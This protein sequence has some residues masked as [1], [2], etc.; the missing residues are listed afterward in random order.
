MTLTEIVGRVKKMGVNLVEVTGG[1]PLAQDGV[2][3]LLSAL[4]DGGFEVLLETSGAF[5]ISDIDERV[6]VI[7]DVKCPGSGMSDKICFENLNELT[8][9]RHELKFVVSSRADF[10]W[11]IGLIES[12]NLTNR[13]E[14][15]IS[16]V[17]PELSLPDVADWIMGSRLPLR[18]HLQLQK[19]I[20]NNPGADQ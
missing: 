2:N 20:W 16:P 19:Y 11:A 7:M 13:A 4:C 14:L 15:L 8:V 12:L 10:D 18:L 6:R 1:E 5:S 3:E 17:L 9:N